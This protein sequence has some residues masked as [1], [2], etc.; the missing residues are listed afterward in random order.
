[1]ASEVQI[2][3]VPMRIMARYVENFNYL[4]KSAMQLFKQ[5][6]LALI[7]RQVDSHGFDKLLI[8]RTEPGKIF[9]LSSSDGQVK[10]QFYNPHE[11]ILKIFVQ[12]NDGKA[13]I[14]IISVNNELRLDPKTGDRISAFAHK[15]D[16][17]E[18]SFMQIK[19]SPSTQ[20][21]IAVPKGAQAN[22]QVLKKT[23]V[24]SSFLA[25]D[26]PLFYT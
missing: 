21:V 10:W 18:H 12:L 20:T 24:K 8:L 23:S 6:D 13:E 17:K 25:I 4:V 9:A 3:E 26:K 14:V 19:T 11:H 22:E 2:A 5:E 16:T 7:D 1:M 15:I